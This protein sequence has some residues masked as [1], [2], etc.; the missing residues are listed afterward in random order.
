MRILKS[1]RDAFNGIGILIRTERNFQIHLVAFVLAMG[2]G[3][4]FNI[5]LREFGTILLVSALMFSVEGVNTAIEKLC[6]EVTEERKESIRVVKDISA[7]AVLIVAIF[8]LV[9]GAS[10]FVPYIF[11][12]GKYFPISIG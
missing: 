12:F 7:G 2:G 6:D 10:I 8:A 5:Q 1:F 4:Y 9:I 11:G 3:L